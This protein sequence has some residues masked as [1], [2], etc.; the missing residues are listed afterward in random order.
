MVKDE[1]NK[2]KNKTKKRVESGIDRKGETDK[3][4]E[5]GKMEYRKGKWKTGELKRERED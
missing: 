5:N 1:L 4:E 3:K 2:D